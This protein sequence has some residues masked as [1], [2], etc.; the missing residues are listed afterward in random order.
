MVKK[1]GSY[2][3]EIEKRLYHSEN[4]RLKE[5]KVSGTGVSAV[6]FLLS[7]NRKGELSLV[8]TKRSAL[9][10][11]PGDLC[12]P[13]GRISPVRDRRLSR[14]LLLPGMPLKR[15]QTWQNIRKRSR[16]SA[17]PAAMLV[18]AA[19][20]ESW[21]EIG[22][23]PF[24]VRLLGSLEPRQLTVFDKTIFPICA[25]TSNTGRLKPNKEVESIHWI[26]LSRLLDA[27][28]YAAYVIRSLKEDTETRPVVKE[29]ICYRHREG[30]TGER[31]EILW[32]AAL[33]VTLSFLKTVYDFSPPARETLPLVEDVFS[34][35]YFGR[36]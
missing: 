2:P 14:L 19:L 6:L 28:N 8:L 21:E 32:G 33:G 24:Q 1:W 23:N 20:R 10:S 27:A 16:K 5:I 15:W 30:E 29:T 25:W 12:S 13:G 31:E 4:K 35:N 36:V 9:V 26:P 18:T 7:E 11:Q 22:L 17:E 34:E 3:A